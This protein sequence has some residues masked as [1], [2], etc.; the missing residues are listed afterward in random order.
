MKK[1]KK[2]LKETKRNKIRFYANEDCANNGC[3]TSRPNGTCVNN[4]CA[5]DCKWC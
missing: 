3:T 1:L 2:P 5:K 4:G